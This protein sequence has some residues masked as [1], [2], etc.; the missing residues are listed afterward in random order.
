MILHQRSYTTGQFF[1][2]KPVVLE[3]PESDLIVVATP[4][5]PL[6]HAQKAAEIIVDQF[7]LLSKEDL[8]TPFESIPSLNPAANRLRMGLMTANNF[9][10]KGE[11]AK[12]WKSAVEITAVHFANNVLSWAHVG[13][14]HL[15]LTDAKFSHPLAY[16]LD[17]DAQ[18]QVQGPLFSQALG[19]EAQLPI[20]AGSVRTSRGARLLMLARSHWPREILGK[21]FS[22]NTVEQ[23]MEVLLQTLV[24]ENPENPFWFGLCDLAG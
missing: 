24:E 1:R 21:S 13:S 14:P 18:T 7:E 9:L 5:G 16:S 22:K 19:I 15:L 6:E 23:E 11:N 2:P 17:W 20:S 10:F 3:R 12:A 8:T 4:W